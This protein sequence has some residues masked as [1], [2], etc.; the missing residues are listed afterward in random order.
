MKDLPSNHPRYLEL[1][2]QKQ[3]IEG[4]L[5]ESLWNYESFGEIFS[6]KSSNG[7][8]LLWSTN[9]S[10]EKEVKKFI[11]FL[12]A[13]NETLQACIENNCQMLITHHPF[14]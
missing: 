7:F 2:K 12:N 14:Y 6:F 1:E 13:D 4:E 10:R 8:W 11:L 3:L 9:W 5:N